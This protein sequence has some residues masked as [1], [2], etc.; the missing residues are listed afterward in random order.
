[1]AAQPE[2]SSGG[3]GHR[4]S[5][6]SLTGGG[7]GQDEAVEAAEEEPARAAPAAAAAA[8]SPLSYEEYECRICYNLFDLERHAPKLLECL[9][10]FCLECLSQ[11]HLRAAHSPHSQGSGRPASGAAEPVAGI[12]C[13]L[14]RHCT[15]LLGG[16]AQSLPI[17]TKRVEAILL[18]L[19]GWAPLLQDRLPPPPPPLV[20]QA[21]RPSRQRPSPEHSG[22]G[23]MPSAAATG[24]ARSV[25]GGTSSQESGG[26]D[27]L[28]C[29]SWRKKA[30]CV[31]VFFSVL[32]MVLLVFAWMEWLT[33]SIFLGVALAILFSSTMPFMMY[34]IKFRS[35]PGTVFLRPV[36]GNGS[37]GASPRRVALQNRPAVDRRS[38]S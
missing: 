19:R 27:G 15:V 12:T 33:G 3:G 10:T 20:L 16:S 25:E 13:P 32:S 38:R 30:G 6:G 9:H 1:M 28:C 24:T 35:Q 4:Q 29:M 11:L 23:A 31:C 8:E 34:R 22:V 21:P 18:Q 2:P 7:G 37:R 5:S 36:E 14:C 17:N 26:S